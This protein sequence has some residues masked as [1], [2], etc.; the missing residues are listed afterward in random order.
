MER[1]EQRN[2]ASVDAI[3]GYK[4]TMSGWQSDANC[5][6]VPPEFFYPEKQASRTEIKMA[7]KVCDACVVRDECLTYALENSEGSGIWGG[8]TPT[9][10]KKLKGRQEKEL[11]RQD[12]LR[13]R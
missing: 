12:R 5:A 11:T 2:N 10:R 8:L 4:D 1:R 9:E 3:D 6:T 7:K 13:L